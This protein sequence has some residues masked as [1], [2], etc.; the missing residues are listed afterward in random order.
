LST[1]QPGG[2]GDR[3]QNSGG[4]THATIMTLHRLAGLRRYCASRLGNAFDRNS[5]GIWAGCVE[6]IFM[7]LQ[8]GGPTLAALPG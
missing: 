3:K 5:P 8:T 2:G 4:D 1:E 7:R 6:F